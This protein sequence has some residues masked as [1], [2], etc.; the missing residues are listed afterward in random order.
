M[1]Q[2]KL[3]EWCCLNWVSLNKRRQSGPKKDAS[4]PVWKG[5]DLLWVGLVLLWAKKTIIKSLDAGAGGGLHRQPMLPGWPTKC[6]HWGIPG[7]WHSGTKHT[8]VP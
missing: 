3:Y 6:Q 2:E 1:A 8:Y 5:T 7:E 4:L